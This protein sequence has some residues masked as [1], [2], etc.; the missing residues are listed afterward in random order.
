MTKDS[1]ADDSRFKGG[2]MDYSND[3]L[4][5]FVN[6]DL[7]KKYSDENLKKDGKVNYNTNLSK[8]LREVEA[9]AAKARIGDFPEQYVSEFAI[10]QRMIDHAT[11]HEIASILGNKKQ[12]EVA[13]ACIKHY[14]SK[15]HLPIAGEK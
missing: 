5:D 14:A 10:Y 8:I 13:V 15:L 7:S 4:K 2:N 11:D 6:N 3:S 9:I 1:N 12:M